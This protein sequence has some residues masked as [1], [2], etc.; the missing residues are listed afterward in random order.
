[1]TRLIVAFTLLAACVPLAPTTP[2]SAPAPAPAPAGD[3][4]TF[5]LRPVRVMDALAPGASLTG[6]G[7]FMT[8]SQFGTG[9]TCGALYKTT[10]YEA[11][12]ILCADQVVA[13]PLTTSEQI[14]AVFADLRRE[15]DAAVAANTQQ[16]QMAYQIGRNIRAN[17]PTGCSNCTY[18]VYDASGNYL[19]DE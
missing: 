8:W 6:D 11:V 19:R 12:F 17:W 7:D 16:S 18:R 15:L 13:G 9:A 5:D 4:S 14:E 1:M 3:G 10:P 2:A